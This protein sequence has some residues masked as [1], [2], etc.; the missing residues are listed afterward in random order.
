M[1]FYVTDNAYSTGPVSG[2]IVFKVGSY[3]VSTNEDIEN[4]FSHSG[5]GTTVTVQ[6]FDSDNEVQSMDIDLH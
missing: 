1:G 6:Y 3:Y 2:D 5:P 4:A